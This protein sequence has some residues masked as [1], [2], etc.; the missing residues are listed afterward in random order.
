MNRRTLVDPS[1]DVKCAIVEWMA[2]SPKPSLV[3]VCPPD[4]VFAPLRPYFKLSWRREADVPSDFQIIATPK[5]MIKMHWNMQGDYQVL[6]RTEHKNE[7]N[8]R[9]EWVKFNNLVAVYIKSEER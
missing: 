4:E 8:A 1:P 3:V 6:L 7:R 5:A 2:T 9:A